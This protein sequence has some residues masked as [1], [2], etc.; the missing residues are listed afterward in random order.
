MHMKIRLVFVAAVLVAGM[1][2]ASA[3]A[4]D[5]LAV[6]SVAAVKPYSPTYLSMTGILGGKTVTSASVAGFKV[7]VRNEAGAPAPSFR[8]ALTLEQKGLRTLVETQ[9]FPALRQEEAA[10]VTFRG[11]PGRGFTRD[12]TLRIALGTASARTYR[13]L[14]PWA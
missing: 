1:G 4:N 3:V 2:P 11:F 13:V 10:T 8:V 5:G 12:T 7:K 14:V 9:R 6:A